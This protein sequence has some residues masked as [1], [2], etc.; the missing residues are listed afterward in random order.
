[1]ELLVVG[2]GV[3]VFWIGAWATAGRSL[4]EAY[5]L[6]P[7]ILISAMTAWAVICREL[8]SGE[9]DWWA[10]L[11]LHAA[12]AGAALWHLL[13]IVTEKE[14][15]FYSLYALIDLPIFYLLWAFALVI[16]LQFP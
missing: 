13:L 8:G 3:A 14:Q 16:A 10:Q 11:P 12:F 6:G 7:P 2:I 15:A 5:R 9:S 4:I 1:M